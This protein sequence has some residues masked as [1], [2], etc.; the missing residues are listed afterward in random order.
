MQNTDLI[1]RYLQTFNTID[2]FL[3][4]LIEVD[5]FMPYNEKLKIISEEKTHIS[6]FIQKYEHKLRFFGEIRNHISH[7]MRIDEQSYITPTL[8][9][10]SELEKFAEAILKPISAYTLFGR[11]V[12][13]CHT[14]DLVTE[15]V[16]NM[17]KSNATHIP[18]YDEKHHFQGL[19]SESILCFQL[20]QPENA[21]QLDILTVEKL[22]LS[23]AK[24]EAA[25]ISRHENIYQ[26]E[27][28]FDHYAHTTKRLG[29]L[30]ITE[31]GKP[32]ELPLGIVTAH[33]LPLITQHL[34]MENV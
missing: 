22:D 6:Y 14:G 33:D 11:K 13:T 27:Q 9:A 12:I 30:I 3:D 2:K 21:H 18:L 31:N 32:D 26:V 8:F 28:R 4:T 34:F 5:G 20:A 7:S 19:I 23:G 1:T 24:E 17:K 10:V 16:A 15:V 29:A 25:F